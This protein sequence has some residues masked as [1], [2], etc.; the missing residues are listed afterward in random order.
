MGG[1]EQGRGEA[2]ALHTPLKAE[3]AFPPYGTT[4]WHPDTFPMCRRHKVRRSVWMQTVVVGRDFG[5]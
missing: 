4:P 5:A 3:S 2:G 1:C